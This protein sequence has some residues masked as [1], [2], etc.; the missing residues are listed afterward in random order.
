MN[1][2]KLTALLLLTLL[3]LVACG[4]R[5]PLVLPKDAPPQDT[6]TQRD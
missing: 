6:D 4:N 3:T 5:G 1:R 2:P